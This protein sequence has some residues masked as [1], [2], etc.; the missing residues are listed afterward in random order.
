[1]IKETLRISVSV[2]AGLPRVVPPSGAVISGV[3]IPGGVSASYLTYCFIPDT[4][5][6]TI[7]SQ[8]PLFVS[9]SEEIFARAH[10]FTPDRWL[11]PESKALENYL[12][13]FSKGPRACLG[14]K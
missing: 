9:F 1:M 7:V 8:S 10:E 11:Q 2:P 6:Q 14:I 3:K 12:V 13:V 5:Q 4:C